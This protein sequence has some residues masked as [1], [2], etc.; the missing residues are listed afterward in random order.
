VVTVIM[1]D[2]GAVTN[3]GKNSCTNSFTLAVAQIAHAPVI[4]WATNRTVLEN[5]SLTG[6]INVWDYDQAGSNLVLSAVSV[7]TNIAGV[8]VTTTNVASVTNAVFGLAFAPVTNTYGPATI[9]LVASEVTVVSNADTTLTTNVL[10]STN[11]F[12]LTVLPVSQPPSFVMTNLLTVAE[13]SGLQ[14]NVNFVTAIN[15]GVGNVAGLTWTFRALT[16]TNYVS[17]NA[18]FAVLPSV[19]TNG[20]LTFGLAAHSYGT[21]VVT[22]IMTDSGAVTNGGK[23]S[24]T[25]S[26]TLA[27]APIAHAPVIT[28]ATNRTVLENG[29]LTG[30]INV[31]DYD[32]AGSNLVLSAVS[33]ATNIAG[34]SMTTTNVASAT[35]ALFGLAFAPVTNT[36]GSATIQLVASEVTVVSNAD[37]TLTTNALATTNSFTL[38]VLPVSQP[39]SFGMTNLL[40]V[41]EESG[42]QT[43]V[44]FVTAINV[45]AGNM[46]G[47]TW[48]FRALTT[49]NY[50]STNAHF[51]VSPSLATNGTL[52]FGLAAH[53]YGTNVVTV[54]MTD[55]GVITN[56]GVNSCTNSFTLAVGQ[57]AHAPVITWATNRTVLENRS[58]TGTINVWDLDQAGSNLV[59]SAVSMATN[60]AAVSVATTNVA[61]ATNALFGLAFAPVTNTYGPA[62]IQLVASEVTV[63]SNADT[64]LTTNVLASTNSFTLT[65]LPV[66][67]PPSFSLATNTLSVVENPGQGVFGSSNFLTGISAGA[68]NPPGLTWTFAVFCATNQTTNATFTQFPTVTTNGTLSFLTKDYSFGTNLVTVVMTD[69]GRATNGGVIAFTNSF[70]LDVVQGQYP[71]AFTGLL[72]NKTILE[73]AHTNLSVAFTLFDPLTTNFNLSCTSANSNVVTGSVTGTGTALTLWLAPVTN[74]F[75]SNITVTVTASDGILTNSASMAVTVVW[76]NQA[77]S[78]NLAFSSLTVT[79]FNVALAIP[80][81]LTNILAGPTNESSQTVSFTVTNSKPGLFLTQ[82]SV[83]ALGTLVF[84]PAQTGG[85]ARVGIQVRDNGGTN[86]GGVSTSA[87]Q[88]LTITVPPNPFQELAGSFTG[89]F[90]DTNR[91]TVD[92]SGFFSLTPAS[93]GAFTGYFLCAG[94]SNLFN[95]QFSILDSNSAYANLLAAGYALNL[96]ADTSGGWPQSICGSVSNTATGW[97]AEL[98]SFLPGYSATFTTSRAGTNLMTMPGSDIALVSPPGDSIFSMVI[99]SNGVASLTGLLADDTAVSQINPI[100]L[101]G[102]FPVYIPLYGVDKGLLL[103]WL[104]LT[105]TPGDSVS[106][107]STLVWLNQAGATSLYPAGF[108]NSAVP[109][110]SYYHATL[111]N[112]LGSTSGLVILSG[113][114]LTGPLTN[115]VTITGNVITVTPPA[116]NGLSLYINNTSGEVQGSFIS[117]G[118]HTNFIDSVIIQSANA[119]AGYYIE[120]QTNWCGSFILLGN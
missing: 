9:Q 107:N 115:T 12:T 21:N 76:V 73:N 89:L 13:E 19:A 39:P 71:P 77:P 101:A 95:G 25:N 80:N 27:V 106:T 93:D 58:L 59:L 1:T 52:V 11:S 41:A 26:F 67:Q 83:T 63:V 17:T 47:L 10:A 60:I 85:T 18:H 33:M 104:D 68:G 56:G 120:A 113:G 112:L 66:S 6:T 14:T 108:T 118:N 35:N 49:T 102:Y 20:T 50:A 70:Q 98:A 114:G 36:Y 24:C 62:T 110:A 96:A 4:T 86:N 23:N 5:A 57:I 84:T 100:S 8:S 15:V 16:A 87:F 78:F 88:I 69:S 111:T 40:T 51:T 82:P 116:T 3:G 105:G 119:A 7:T 72:T 92:G 55:S 48:T 34:V 65:V 44:N 31:W 37:T 2:S 22:V 43:N 90:Y 30:T 74:A 53:S 54:I 64:T 117:S 75:G 46:P 99:S 38:T 91:A 79:Q 61:S 29:N 97:N 103:G 109:A 32:Q 28:W 94:S 81:A 42:L 45:G